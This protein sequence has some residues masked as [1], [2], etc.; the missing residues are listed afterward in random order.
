[1]AEVQL[2]KLA[3][4]N[5]GSKAVKEFGLQMASDH[6]KAN[7]KLKEIAA[8]KDVELPTSPAKK[9]QAFED[10]FQT[11]SGSNFDKAY[12]SH[13]VADHRMDIAEFEKEAKNGKDAEVKAFASETLPTLREHLKMAQQTQSQVKR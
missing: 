1:M 5:A 9:E 8:S 2:G 11:M 13:M 12:I 10:K 6:A 3:Q 7:D 4:D